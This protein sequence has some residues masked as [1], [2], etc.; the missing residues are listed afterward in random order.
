MTRGRSRSPSLLS[1]ACVFAFYK[2]LCVLSL[3]YHESAPATLYL[4][5]LEGLNPNGNPKGLSQPWKR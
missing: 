3:R 2:R 4:G 1:S 5:S